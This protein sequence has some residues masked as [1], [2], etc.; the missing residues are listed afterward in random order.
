MKEPKKV[1]LFSNGNV[2]CS[3]ENGDQIPE[4]QKGWLQTWY[5]HMES[6][7]VD[8]SKIENIGTVVNGRMVRLKPFKHEDGTWNSQFEDYNKQ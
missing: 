8:P 3:D 5:E 4:L 6:I 2:S 7:G 1:I